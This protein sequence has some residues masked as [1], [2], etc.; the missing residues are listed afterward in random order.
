MEHETFPLG[1][2]EIDLISGIQRDGAILQGRL[3]GILDS[4]I[5]RNKL[6]GRWELAPNGREIYRP[7]SNG[8][9]QQ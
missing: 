9:Q 5:K 6:E 2:E 1:D 3:I 8:H 7:S 4:Y